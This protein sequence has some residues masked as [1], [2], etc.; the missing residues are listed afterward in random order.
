[1]LLML[2]SCS[3][4]PRIAPGQ[5][6]PLVKHQPHKGSH[7]TMDYQITFAYTFLEGHG[8]E[9]DRI[10]FSGRLIPRRGLD[11]FILRLHF[12]DENGN[13]LGTQVLYAPGAGRG[14]GRPAI[15][16]MIEVPERA[17]NMGFSHVAREQRIRPRGR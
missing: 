5:Q 16:R 15:S 1:M 6:M 8:G 17:I 14:A 4:S 13:V 3:T 7:R 10:D 9:P 2:A 12:L 11:T